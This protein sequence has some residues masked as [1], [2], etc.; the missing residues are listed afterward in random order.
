MRDYVQRVDCGPVSFTAADNTE[1]LRLLAELIS[2]GL[3]TPGSP[4]PY[5][6]FCEANLLSCLTDDAELREI[7][8]QAAAVFADGIA[9][10]K[11][12]AIYN[13]PL[14]E[15]VPGPG[16]MLKACEAGVAKG[17]RHFFY[18]GG[19]GVADKLAEVLQQ[20]FTGLKVA[21]TFSPPFRE[22]G[23]LDEDDEVLRM[24]EKSGADI[25]WVGLGGPKQ[26]Y[27]MAS[28]ARRIRVP[29]MLGVGA[30]FDFHSGNRPWAPRWIRATGTEW[31][32]RALTGGRSTFVR[33]IRCV[34]R[35]SGL[36]WR[37]M[38]KSKSNRMQ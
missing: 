1:A 16:F 9:A 6:C 33:N 14:P 17:W 26:E 8:H 11:L 36:L 12:A 31:I 27:W 38:R 30:A 15:R 2:G 35:V 37:E 19:E 29:V 28:H 25:L 24:I 21:G 5:V 13:H 7:L 10:F 34:S 18:G 23:A 3:P 22:I 20:K 32:F 4:V